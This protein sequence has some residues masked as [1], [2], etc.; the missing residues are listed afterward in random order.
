MLHL[1]KN[2]SLYLVLSCLLHC[3]LEENLKP[4]CRRPDFGYPK[5]LWRIVFA[6]FENLLHM[7]R[8]RRVWAEPECRLGLF[9]CVSAFGRFAS[10]FSL[11]RPPVQAVSSTCA[12]CI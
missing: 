8:R 5:N 7:L 10:D 6:A 2:V 4:T 1:V 12:V 9:V 3:S 11:Q